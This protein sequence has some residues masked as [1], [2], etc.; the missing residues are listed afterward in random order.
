[1]VNPGQAPDAASRP[2]NTAKQTANSVRI[3]RLGANLCREGIHDGRVTKPSRERN[4]MK[5]KLFAAMLAAL[6]LATAGTAA[7]HENDRGWRDRDRWERQEIT[8]RNDGR[9][10]RV[11]RQDR[12]FYRLISQ[13]FYFQ[14]GYTYS[15]TDRC[16]RYGCVVFVFDQRHRRPIDRIFAPHLPHRMY[17]WRT[18]RGFDPGFR[19]FGRYQRDDYRWDNDDERRYRDWRGRD[20]DDDRWDDDDDDRRRRR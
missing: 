19:A 6:T 12:L 17:A 11:D 13:P 1:M 4:S 3:Q 18:H 10:F 2:A 7:A 14:P 9:T 15:Y 8:I 5:T 20:H 16:N